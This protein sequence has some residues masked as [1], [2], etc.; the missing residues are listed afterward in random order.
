MVEDVA[1]VGRIAVK[2]D[3]DTIE[4]STMFPV[5]ILLIPVL[6]ALGI[7]ELDECNKNKKNEQLDEL[8]T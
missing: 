7:V 2:Q 8:L 4:G 3:T 5:L 1:Q 6:S